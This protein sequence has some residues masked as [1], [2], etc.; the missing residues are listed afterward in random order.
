MNSYRQLQSPSPLRTSIR[1]TFSSSSETEEEIIITTPRK[2]SRDCIQFQHC[3]CECRNRPENNGHYVI[4]SRSVSP[5]KEGG[6]KSK[7]DKPPFKAGRA[8][9][10]LISKRD[11]GTSSPRLNGPIFAERKSKRLIL[12]L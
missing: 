7:F 6:R 12:F 10:T 5:G 1:N 3:V 9:T 2:G 4:R 11:F 8:P